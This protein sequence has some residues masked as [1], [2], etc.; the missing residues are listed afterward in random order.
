MRSFGLFPFAPLF[1]S[2]VVG[3]QAL[4]VQCSTT[5]GLEGSI[6]FTDMEA[7]EITNTLLEDLYMSLRRTLL[8]STSQLLR[9]NTSRAYT[10]SKFYTVDVSKRTNTGTVNVNDEKYKVHHLLKD[11]SSLPRL[12]LSSIKNIKNW[13]VLKL[14]PRGGSPVFA[15]DHVTPEYT[16]YDPP[17]GFTAEQI[18]QF[19]GAKDMFESVSD[20]QKLIE[21]RDHH[22]TLEGKVS[23]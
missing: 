6:P 7:L 12:I 9:Y 4:P 20:I 15:N 17:K 16:S 13:E 8:A 3:A 14:D 23:S 18:I 1:I 19:I 11:E 10:S 5:E 2:V 21:L 22:G